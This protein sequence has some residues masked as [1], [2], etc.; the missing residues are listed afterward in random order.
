MDIVA[1]ATVAMDIV[2]QVDRLPKEDGF[3]VVQS[4]T[5]VDGGS[6][7]NAIVQAAR[8]G[9]K[10]GFIAKL[11]D[12]DLGRR[13]LAGLAR[14]GV[15]TARVC[16]KKGG[17]SLH[18]QVVVGE[19][20]KKFILL[21]LG[22]A[23]LELTKEE[24]DMDYIKQARVF[25]TDLLPKEPAVYALQQAKASGQ[26]TVVNLQVG[27]ETLQGFGFS[28]DEVLG[29]LAYADVV[30]MNRD[31]FLE[32]TGAGNLDQGFAAIRDHCQGIPLVTLGGQG[33]TTFYRGMRISVPAYPVEVVDTTGA[34]DAYIGAFMTAHF[35]K[36]MDVGEAME[37]ASAAAALTCT[38][39]GAR[40]SPT[41]DEV[42]ALLRE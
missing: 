34:G 27:L 1:V 11:G 5:M 17:T 26:K 24:L 36:G 7:A 2:L 41:W 8:M 32:L 30:S 40:S 15:D 38:K 37:F 12:D 10:C 9:A 29:L 13:F 25:Y 28:R 21:N 31:T 39:I 4:T 14:E 20:G 3:A 35:M 16:I 42:A 18:T 33:S 19:E 6:G 22:D 23:F